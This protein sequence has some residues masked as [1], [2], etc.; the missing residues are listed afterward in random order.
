MTQ[1]GDTRAT[2]GIGL[3]STPL[4]VLV[5]TQPAE[6]VSAAMAAADEALDRI[7][8]MPPIYM[9]ELDDPAADADRTL[10][11]VPRVSILTPTIEGREQLLVEAAA[12]VQAQ[13]EEVAHLIYLDTQREGPAVCRN[14]MLDLVQSEWVGFLDDDDLLDPEHV[15]A[16]MALLANGGEPPDLAWPR[17]RTQFAD[18]VP[19]TRIAQGLRPDYRQLLNGG[20][21]FI[22]ITVIART[23]S[24]RAAGGFDPADRY[25]DYELWRRMLRQ[26]QRFV[27]LPH[28]TWTYRFLGE[29][30]THG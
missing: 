9:P 8:G 3:L 22:P 21:N 19:Q 24:I 27:H 18:G 16:L 26:G 6:A 5:P 29:N 7:N 1:P 12:S 15:E 28:A 23:D 25:E 14:R 13:T 17:C 30:R 2:S 20:R 10:E 4:G 11:E